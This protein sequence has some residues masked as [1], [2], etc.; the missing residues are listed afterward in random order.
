MESIVGIHAVRQAL[1]AG[2]GRSLTVRPGK[3]NP[4]LQEVVDLAKQQGVEVLVGEVRHE[5][6]ADQGVALVVK[7]PQIRSESLLDDLI[8]V[9]SPLF[10]MLDGV[11]DPRNLGA[12]LRSAASFGVSAVVAPK[13]RSAPLNEAAVKTASGAA[14]LVPYVQVTNLG[15]TLEHLK[16]AGIWVV[17]TVLADDSQ[18]LPAIDLTGP[19]A[20]VMGAEGTGIRAGIRKKCDFLAEIPAPL[21]DLSLNVA[22]AS[23]ICLYEVNQQRGRR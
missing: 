12:C 17:G 1:I 19:L 21:P 18:P 7:T 22:V 23:G 20:M 4:R 8:G 2:E 13:D 6:L 15:R 9:D 5:E 16:K 10:L 14:S 11:T 3:L